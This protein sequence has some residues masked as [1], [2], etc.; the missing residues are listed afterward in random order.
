M[1]GSVPT[2]CY[3]SS[4]REY[5]NQ[6]GGAPDAA[7]LPAPKDEGIDKWENAAKFFD[8]MVTDIGESLRAAEAAHEGRAADAAN[9]SIA[10]I[11]PQPPP[12][13][14]RAAA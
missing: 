2:M 14:K 6:M 9:A 4:A 7:N 10:E 5:R 3:V 11:T 1:T 12:L 8:E 13:P